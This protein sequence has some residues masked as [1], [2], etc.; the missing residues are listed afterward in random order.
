MSSV[1]QYWQEAWT[2]SS[3]GVDLTN[4]RVS[5]RATKANPNKEDSKWWNEI[6]PLWV[7]NYISW[8]KANPNWKLWTAPDGNKAVELGLMPEIAGV[9][10]KMVIDRVFEVDGELVIV[11]LKTSRN[12][13]VSALQLGFY[14]VGLEMQFGV[15]VKWGS[16]YMSRGGG[17]SGMID[18]EEYT[19]EKIEYLVSNFDKAR[20]SGI[21]LPNTSNCEYLCGLTEYCQFYT[22]KEK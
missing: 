17:L 9:Q 20:K 12:T 13:P 18:L 6:G 4:A 10:V 19:M 14:K 11:D 16:Y 15:P 8:R 3:K 21:F 5:G 2:E 22:K 1:T 7:E